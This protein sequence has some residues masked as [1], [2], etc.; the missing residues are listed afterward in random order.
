[1]A[2]IP[3]H[4]EHEVRI[5]AAHADRDQALRWSKRLSQ[6][7]RQILIVCTDHSH[8]VALLELIR[9]L[10][11]IVHVAEWSIHQTGIFNQRLSIHLSLKLFKISTANSAARINTVSLLAVRGPL[12]RLL[13][14][15]NV[16]LNVDDTCALV[17]LILLLLLLLLLAHDVDHIVL[18]LRA[19]LVEGL[20]SLSG[21]S[22]DGVRD[23]LL[24]QVDFTLSDQL[25]MSVCERNLKLLC[26][27]LPQS[28][29]GL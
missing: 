25:H 26:I 13:L 5:I 14:L 8:Q 19:D 9:I 18:L 12:S 17:V 21:S 1:M 27:A 15:V 24:H 29:K 3:T 22:D 2:T 23:G 10:T 20:N 4:Q 6:A 28:S 11:C 16:A 7:G